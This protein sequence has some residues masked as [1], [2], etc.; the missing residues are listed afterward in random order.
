MEY[1]EEYLDMG[2]VMIREQ[3]H[4][5]DHVGTSTRFRTELE[6]GGVSPGWD[7][8][9]RYGKS[10]AP[11]DKLTLTLNLAMVAKAT[12]GALCSL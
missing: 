9:R 10:R 7:A 2:V 1:D 8:S 6:F 4:V 12:L 11:L 3:Y 5:R